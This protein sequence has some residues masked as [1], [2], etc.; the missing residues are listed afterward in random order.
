[1][2]RSPNRE[3]LAS[4]TH[5][6]L[7]QALV[8]ADLLSRIPPVALLPALIALS[9]IGAWPW[10]AA[11]LQAT[12]GVLTL[13]AILVDGISLSL[14]PRFGRS[15]GPPTPPLFALALLRAGVT[16]ALG[17][18]SPTWPTLILCALCQ[19]GLVAVQIY[20]TWIEPARVT[21]T[22]QRLTTPKLRGSDPLRL[23]HVSDIH[24]EGWTPREHRLLRMVR[25]LQPDLILL[26]GD[27]LNLSSIEETTAH[28][29]ARELLAC[30]A[31][32]APTYAITGSPPVDHA[33]VVPAIFEGLP[34]T[35]LMD[36]A[37]TVRIRGHRL[38]LVGIRCTRDRHADGAR[39]RQLLPDGVGDTFTVLLY[40]SPDLMPD[41]VA[42]GIDLYLAGHTHGGQL[43]L[44][45]FGALV[46]SSDFGKR[47]EMGRYRE[48][49]TILYVSRG[50][51][52][53]GLGAP[54]ARFL[55]PPEIVVWDLE[56]VQRHTDAEAT[57]RNEKSPSA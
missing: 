8:V 34:I 4:T 31:A 11:P 44:P 26:T 35:W 3:P 48:S 43:R 37:A 29:E 23:L 53:E 56:A 55:A 22:H 39:L 57:A 20:A 32:C 19:V 42:C 49:G 52:V 47:Y 33:H 25:S 9:A 10:R 18:I 30:L 16:F 13:A 54:R 7:L 28:A 2:D 46:T 50:L 27:Y 40:H 24:F 21:V 38:L 14:L 12:T 17:A 41:A 51:G 45:L 15:Y 6:P 1:M 36:Q 5:G